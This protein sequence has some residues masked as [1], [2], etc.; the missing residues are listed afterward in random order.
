LVGDGSTR[1]VYLGAQ[2]RRGFVSTFEDVVRA[3]F[4]STE[5][6]IVTLRPDY[7]KGTDQRFFYRSESSWFRLTCI[8]DLQPDPYAT[9]V[10]ALANL[11]PGEGAF[12][13]AA[14]FRFDP[15]IEAFKKPAYAMAA[16]E[17]G[18]AEA[19]AYEGE[20]ITGNVA[21][22]ERSVRPHCGSSEYRSQYMRA[23]SRSLPFHQRV[24]SF[25]RGLR[26]NEHIS[27]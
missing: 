16:F 9:L 12:Y 11:K 22:F 24:P 23:Q 6:Q 10:H 4:P 17:D 5:F 8:T 3:H 26:I 18:L 15:Q 14:F 27:P 13:D 2:L 25:M 20:R 7:A 1:E 19:P 21:D